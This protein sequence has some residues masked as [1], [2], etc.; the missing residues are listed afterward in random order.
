M[1][2]LLDVPIC[3]LPL[4]VIQVI[5]PVPEV[6]LGMALARDSDGVHE[7]L[8]DVVLVAIVPL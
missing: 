8:V 4:Y 3:V 2:V 6:A 5:V 1:K 7:T